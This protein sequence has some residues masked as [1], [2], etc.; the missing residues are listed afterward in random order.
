[1]EVDSCIMIYKVGD[2][3]MACD[4]DIGLIEGIIIDTKQ[5][6]TVSDDNQYL[7]K[8]EP[9]LIREGCIV[10]DVTKWWVDEKDARLFNQ[11]KW[12]KAVKH[13]LEFKKL[14]LMAHGERSR[15]LKALNGEPDDITDITDITANRYNRYKP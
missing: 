11:Y 8:V 14:H 10:Q 6:P 5:R 12:N 9:Y 4:L 3:I 13:W 7:L 2:R 15:M 1:M